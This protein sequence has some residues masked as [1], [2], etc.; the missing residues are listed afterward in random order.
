MST[1]AARLHQDLR[2]TAQADT[3]T[4]APDVWASAVRRVERQ[5]E[6]WGGAAGR[7]CAAAR[8]RARAVCPFA[9]PGLSHPLPLH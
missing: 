2:A 4:T 5:E 6:R 7:G 8:A 1:P 3:H 9:C